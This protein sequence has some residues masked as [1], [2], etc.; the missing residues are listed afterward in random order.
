MKL[1]LLQPGYESFTGLFGVTMFENGVSVGDVPLR[2]ARN[3]AISIL[4]QYEDGSDPNPAQGVLNNMNLE[5]QVVAPNSF[6]THVEIGNKQAPALLPVVTREEL[7]GIADKGGIKALRETAST[8]G[9]KGTSI[10]EIINEILEV[11]EKQAKAQ[12]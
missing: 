4:T 3:I 8:Y 6:E 10:A 9:V 1:K 2:E 12:G 7:E 11:I 5:A